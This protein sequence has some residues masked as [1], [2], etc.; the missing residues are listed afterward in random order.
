MKKLLLLLPLGVSSLVAKPATPIMGFSTWN[1]F[2][3]SINE[4]MLQD[5]TDSMVA[6]GLVKSGYN[7][8]NIDDLWAAHDRNAT[9]GIEA[10]PIKFPRGM[11]AF[12][13]YVNQRGM[14]LGLYTARNTR[15]CSGQ[16]PGSLGHEQQ[17][18]ATFA[19]MGAEFLKNDD[20]S[21]IYANAAKDY[22]AMQQAIASLP[23]VA[24]I[25]STKAPDLSAADAPHVTQFRRVAKDLLDDWEDVMRLL[26]TANDADFLNVVGP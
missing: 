14:K 7:Y 12:A 22:G 15:T 11:K 24:M 2:K 20:C 26:D 17:D 19:W 13:T 8:M 23:N 1:C 21:V 10:D 5:V 3:G 9:G 4:S 16:M 25:H 6:M 18:A